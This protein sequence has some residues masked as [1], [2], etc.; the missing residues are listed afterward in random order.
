MFY[1]AAVC[2]LAGIIVLFLMGKIRTNRPEP[3]YFSID[4]TNAGRCN[5]V[6]SFMGLNSEGEKEYINFTLYNENYYLFLVVTPGC[7]HCTELLRNLND[8]WEVLRK[9][10]HLQL[11]VLSPINPDSK[12]Y[13]SLPYFRFLSVAERDLFQFGIEV[14]VFYFV[15]GRGDILFKQSGYSNKLVPVISNL[16]EKYFYRKSKVIE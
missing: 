9:F 2:F 8:E 6:F 7:I 1:F 3:Q 4:K 15:N 13:R 11:F 14:P 10:E 5:R 12:D 16:F